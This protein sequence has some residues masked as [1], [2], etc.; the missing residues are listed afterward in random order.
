MQKRTIPELKEI[1]RE[2]RR[3]IIKML[4]EAKS[5][6]TGGPLGATDI[7]TAL[8]FGG[9]MNYR[10][11]EPNWSD[12]DRFILS[13]GHMVPVLYSTLAEAGYFPKEE[14]MTLRKFGTRL[15]GHPGREKGLPGIELSCG[16]LGQ[17]LSV[18]VG[19][20]L[21][22]K[23]LDKANWRVY[24]LDTDGE[25]QEGS[26][27]EAAMC[28]GHYKLDNLCAIVDRNYIQIDGRTED[29][30]SLDPLS[31]KWKAFKWHV[32][33]INGNDYEQLLKAFDEAKN[34]KGKP[35]VIIARTIMSKGVPSI[36]DDYKWHGKPPKPDEAKKFLS[37]LEAYKF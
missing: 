10:P 35:T 23:Y 8:F 20:A 18:A 7:L 19:I 30:M 16:S 37:E 17:G 4:T 13:A 22:G 28:A 27:W 24:C 6:H 3:N 12:R 34:T 33:E 2:I 32:I 21:S 26:I 9:V 31:D 14:L 29:V 15:Q 36:E 11:N 5:G 1:S 25:L